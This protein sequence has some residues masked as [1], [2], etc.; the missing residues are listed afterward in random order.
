MR[1]PAKTN[2][3]TIEW[4]SEL[5]AQIPVSLTPLSIS[6]SDPQIS[7]AAKSRVYALYALAYHFPADQ[8]PLYVPVYG[9]D[10]LQDHLLCI[11]NSLGKPLW[12]QA[13]YLSNRIRQEGFSHI[14]FDGVDKGIFETIRILEIFLPN[15]KWVLLSEYPL[16]ADSVVLHSP[17]H[18][19][20]KE[21]LSKR[22]FF[23]A[24]LP[25]GLCI[26]SSL[27]DSLRY[28]TPDAS[29]VLSPRVAAQIRGQTTPK[30]HIPQLSK[31]LVEHLCV[32][33]GAPVPSTI[34]VPSLFALRWIMQST[35]H[36]ELALRASLVC[37]HL[38]ILW[39][40]F[41]RA[42]VILE[43]AL[44]RERSPPLRQKIMIFWLFGYAHL[45]TGD[46]S[47][48]EY[49]YQQ[50]L[51]I[52]KE[53]SDYVG[54]LFLLRRYCETGLDW[55]RTEGIETTLHSALQ[56]AHQIKDEASEASLLRLMADLSILQGER[57]GAKALL[58]QAKRIK[59]TPIE[60]ANLYISQ[61]RLQR[62][63]H[64]PEKARL[65]L[66]E[67][68]KLALDQ[69]QIQAN[70]LRVYAECLFLDRDYAQAEIFLKRSLKIYKSTGSRLA[71]GTT[72]RTL[73]D[74]LAVLS[75]PKES[76]QHYQKALT[77]QMEVG[78]LVGLQ[79]TLTNLIAYIEERHPQEAQF[80]RDLQQNL[81][82]K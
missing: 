22:N 29:I 3:K 23:F 57:V 8:I 33:E 45:Q 24:F 76:L 35:Q 52:T 12:A 68:E 21:P 32:A 82:R 5:K 25:A 10:S 50:A 67:A 79:K 66:Q 36:S 26:H 18:P 61:A 71:Q 46:W 62:I 70:R 64:E 56:I 6:F 63:L 4:F 48:M 44:K 58:A 34:D 19:S 9:S 40:Q 51:S 31:I 69:P 39:G 11:A 30:D 41:D 42:F 81:P 13:R 20:P 75:R 47:K 38:Y 60:A 15:I 17:P 78:D 37:A 74:V 55:G 28:P 73:A 49:Y 14:I 53:A 7:L 59:H 16:H 80:L 1:P 72:H 54:M 2:F 65:S 77:I 27:P 43:A